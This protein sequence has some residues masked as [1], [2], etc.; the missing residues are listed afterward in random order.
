MNIL[1]KFESFQKVNFLRWIWS[2]DVTFSW[3]VLP[4]CNN[5]ALDWAF[6]TKLGQ[7][8]KLSFL[9]TYCPR[10]SILYKFGSFQESS[11]FDWPNFVQIWVNLGHYVFKK[12]NFLD[13]A[14]FVQN[15]QSRAMLLQKGN[16]FH[17]KVISLRQIP[18]KKLDSWIVPIL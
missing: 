6:C 7:S 11:F 13:C 4:F 5:I 1:Y 18:R 3:K 2:K 15:A 14:N 9:K 16:T 17:E 12:L 10:F 8:K